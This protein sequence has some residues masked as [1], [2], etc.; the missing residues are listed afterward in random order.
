ERIFV[1]GIKSYPKWSLLT[2]IPLIKLLECVPLK[3]HTVSDLS[4]LWTWL[5]LLIKINSVLMLT[6]ESKRLR[7]SMNE[8]EPELRSKIQSTKL[9]EI[10]TVSN[11]F[12][13][14][15]TWYGFTSKRKDFQSNPMPSYPQELM[16]HFV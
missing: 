6:R 13:M 16:V 7:N 3:W 15:E 5:L 9:S 10:N 4:V 2:T 14:K 12:S 1:N 8:F 11:K